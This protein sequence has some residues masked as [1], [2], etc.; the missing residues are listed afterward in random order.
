M[1]VLRE[2]L[3]RPLAGRISANLG[4]LLAEKCVRILSSLIVGIWVARHLGAEAFGVLS[5]SLALIALFGCLGTLGTDAILK[6]ELL[7]QPGKEE[8]LLASVAVLRVMAAGLAML[9]TFV[10]AFAF[11]PSFQRA[12]FLFAAGALLVPL[13]SMPDLLFQAR[14]KGRTSF[15]AGAVATIAGAVGRVLCILLDAPL[16][17][18]AA[19]VSVEAFVLGIALWTRLRTFRIQIQPGAIDASVAKSL[20]RESLPLLVGGIAVTVYTRIDMVMIEAMRG[21]AEVGVYSAAVRMSEVANFV[22]MVLAAGLFPSLVSAHAASRQEFSGRAGLYYDLSVAVA[23]LFVVPVTLLAGPIIGILFG[24]GYTGAAPVLAV[25]VWSVVFV[26]LGVARSQ[27]L[28]TEGVI[29][30]QTCATMAGAVINI[31]LNALLIPPHGAVGAA[32]ATV[33]S[34]AVAGW[35]S[36]LFARSTRPAFVMQARALLVPLLGWRHLIRR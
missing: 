20:L 24:E 9:F 30:F 3:N 6:R 32:W 17:M 19:M 15:G 4:W 13:L 36:G 29:L 27:V 25:H 21:A 1:S 34:Y 18:F 12:V 28:T 10:W 16:W 33:A 11:L 2:I 26:F 7:R 31:A 5:Y 35:I 23:L 8:T 14:L 22:P